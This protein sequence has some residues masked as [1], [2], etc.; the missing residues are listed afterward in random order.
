MEDVLGTLQRVEWDMNGENDDREFLSIHRLGRDPKVELT[1]EM[2]RAYGNHE[3]SYDVRDISIVDKYSFEFNSLVSSYPTIDKNVSRPSN[4]E[5]IGV[6]L[7][8]SLLLAKHL[9]A[10][11]L[12]AIR[13]YY[14]DKKC[15]I[16]GSTLQNAFKLLIQQT[17]S[18]I[19]EDSKLWEMIEG[20]DYHFPMFFYRMQMV[21]LWD[22]A[23]NWPVLQASAHRDIENSCASAAALKLHRPFLEF[24]KKQRVLHDASYR[25]DIF[26]QSIKWTFDQI[27]AGSTLRKCSLGV[28]METVRTFLAEWICSSAPEPNWEPKIPTEC[29]EFNIEET[30]KYSQHLYFTCICQR[31]LQRKVAKMLC[32]QKNIQES[33]ALVILFILGFPL[34]NMDSIGFEEVIE[35]DKQD[36]GRE[37]RAPVPFSR[38]RVINLI[39]VW[40]A[41]TPIAPQDI[42]L[43]IRI[44]SGR[45]TVSLRLQN[46]SS[47]SRFI[48]QD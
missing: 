21:A 28:V 23:M 25:I 47:D 29:V 12:K 6:G 30:P 3:T 39:T 8:H 9:G 38:H 7:V 32:E 11:K 24:V 41:W 35:Q 36:K 2:S 40:R 14:Y 26:E 33:A 43:K 15:L 46:D 44:D 10:E 42:S 1:G 45:G 31:E 20:F 5:R 34:L 37:A 13:H 48:W 22:E 4:R 18:R 27:D 19:L 17:S 16:E